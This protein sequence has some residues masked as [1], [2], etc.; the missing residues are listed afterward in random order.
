MGTWG[1]LSSPAV[2]D[3]AVLY[4]YSQ[5]GVVAAAHVAGRCAVCR[6]PAWRRIHASHAFVTSRPAQRLST[7]P[8]LLLPRP[9]LLLLPLPLVLVQVITQSLRPA[10]RTQ[11]LLAVV[12]VTFVMSSVLDNLTTTIVMVALLNKL[13]PEP[14]A[15]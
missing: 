8:L 4:T 2:G 14:G 3:D 7:P 6:A 15:F 10:S 11:L 1:G 9:L 13:C 5:R 12:G